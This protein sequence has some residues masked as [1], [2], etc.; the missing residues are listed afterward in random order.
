MKTNNLF[1]IHYFSTSLRVKSADRLQ[2]PNG[3]HTK[4]LD[5][6]PEPRHIRTASFYLRRNRSAE[7]VAHLRS[8]LASQVRMIDCRTLSAFRCGHAG[9]P[10]G[11]DARAEAHPD[12]RVLPALQSVGG[13]RGTS[14]VGAGGRGTQQGPQELCPVVSGPTERS[15]LGKSR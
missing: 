3:L 11:P 12:G 10:R 6:T 5:L 15:S 9:L 14:A 1:E 13:Q 4:R 7:S 2:N 8:L